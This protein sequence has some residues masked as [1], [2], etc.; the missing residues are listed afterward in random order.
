MHTGGPRF[1]FLSRQAGHRNMNVNMSTWWSASLR[2]TP[3][4]EALKHGPCLMGSHRVTC[5]TFYTCKGRAIP[6]YLHPRSSTTVF[7]CLLVA[8]YFT[9]PKGWQPV[10]S[11]RVQYLGVKPGLLASEASV[12]PHSSHC[13]LWDSMVCLP[14]LF[15]QSSRPPSLPS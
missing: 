8:T 6:G 11:S 14:V 9:N 4:A 13:T 2:A 15:T 1:Q 10:L 3:T 5:H 7:H 12:L